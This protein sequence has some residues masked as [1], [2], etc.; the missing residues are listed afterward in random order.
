M[1]NFSDLDQRLALGI[2][3]WRRSLPAAVFFRRLQFTSLQ[4]KQS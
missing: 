3:L 4:L 1:G 2:G